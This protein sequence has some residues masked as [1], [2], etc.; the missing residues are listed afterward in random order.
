MR[1][2]LIVF[3]LDTGVNQCNNVSLN[4][5]TQWS[6]SYV[7]AEP[8]ALVDE[9]GHG[10]HVAN[11][12]G[13]KINSNKYVV[14]VA[15]GVEIAALKVLDK[16]GSGS[17]SNIIS[18][19]NYIYNN[20][21]NI[22]KRIIINM[23]LGGGNSF[24]LKTAVYNL[25]TYKIPVVVAA[26]NSSVNCSSTSPANEQTAITVASYQSNT[27]MAS[28]SNFGSLVDIFAPGSD[29]NSNFRTPCGLF[30]V[31]SGTS[32]ACPM[33]AGTI[34]LYMTLTNTSNMTPQ[35][36]LNNIKTKSKNSNNPTVTLTSVATSAGTPNTSIY[37]G[38]W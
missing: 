16:N 27:Q 25:S 10:S 8:N 28:Y 30:R 26:G 2:T 37:I 38:G 6:K 32:M 7:T 23:S 24:D 31:L 5:N 18:A 14:G 11:I 15:P 12:I 4:I 1:L 9:N 22:G 19:L 36:I 13:A 33:V 3:V 35:E 21:T 20:V 29:I 17:T 34:A